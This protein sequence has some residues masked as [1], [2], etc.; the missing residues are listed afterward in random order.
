LIVTS[1]TSPREASPLPSN[2]ES[3]PVPPVKAPPWMRNMTGLSDSEVFPSLG[4][5]GVQ[6]LRKRQSSDPTL[7]ACTHWLPNDS[8]VV[9]F[10][11]S[12][13]LEPEAVTV[14]EPTVRERKRASLLDNE[15]GLLEGAG[16][17]PTVG[18][19]RCLCVGHG[20]KRDG[21]EDDSFRD[22]MLV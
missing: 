4:R 16:P 2:V 12:Y 21:Q 11:A 14:A 18:C 3:E 7:P 5:Y 6:M 8:A 20:E 10:F 13:T 19:Q 1:T 9:S 17:G 22:I 15:A